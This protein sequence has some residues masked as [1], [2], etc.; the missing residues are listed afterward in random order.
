MKEL[1]FVRYC[2]RFYPDNHP[3][4]AGLPLENPDVPYYAIPGGG[5]ATRPRCEI[6]GLTTGVAV[7][8]E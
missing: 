3:T 2:S 1:T 5:V 6:W 7:R 4:K 8:F